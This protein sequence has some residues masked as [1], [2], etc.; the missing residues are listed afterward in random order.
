MQIFTDTD[1]SPLLRSWLL[2]LERIC[3][4]NWTKCLK[5]GI[6]DS[7]GPRT[8]LDLRNRTKDW[9]GWLKTGLRTKLDQELVHLDSYKQD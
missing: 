3:G 2:A 6:N 9:T 7:I 1:P 4:L 5:K 8:G